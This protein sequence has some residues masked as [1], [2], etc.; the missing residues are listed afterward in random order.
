MWVSQRRYVGVA[1]ALPFFMRHVI[2]EDG[3]VELRFISAIPVDRLL[4]LRSILC[5]LIVS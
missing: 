5:V 4:V 2:F 1:K 3:K